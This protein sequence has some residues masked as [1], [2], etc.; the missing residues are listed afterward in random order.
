MKNVVA[1]TVTIQ[2]EEAE[3]KA[4]YQRYGCAEKAKP[5]RGVYEE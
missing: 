5:Y 2:K 3:G 1:S 4:S